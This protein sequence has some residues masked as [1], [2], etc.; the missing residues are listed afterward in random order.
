MTNKINEMKKEMV[1][2][3]KDQEGNYVASNSISYNEDTKKVSYT[4]S[5]FLVNG[6]YNSSTLEIAQTELDK[7]LALNKRFQLAGKQFH[8]EEIDMVKVMYAESKLN[9]PRYPF[10]TEYYDYDDSKWFVWVI[11]DSQGNFAYKNSI[12]KWDSKTWFYS[13]YKTFGMACRA[14]QNLYKAEQYL[15]TLTK[16]AEEIGLEES[17]HLEYMDINNAIDEH[18]NFK[19]E[20]HIVVFKKVA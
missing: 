17:F 9:I 8:V 5:K 18:E 1:Y 6:F 16:K 19:G 4:Y 12:D 13:S 2:V 11:K 15:E 10:V 14:N 7:L 20:N 3:L